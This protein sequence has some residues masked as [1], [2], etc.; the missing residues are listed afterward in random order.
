MTKIRSIPVGS[1]AY[2]PENC[3]TNEDLAKTV[4]TSDEWIRSRTGIKRRH[5]A[6]EG[7]YT[8]DLAISA[9]NSALKDAGLTGADIDLIVVGTTTPDE[10][11][12]STAVK[13]QAALGMDHGFA[14]DVQAVCSGFVYAMTV[15]DNMIR[16]GDIKR[17]LVIGAETLS[18]ILNWEDRTTCV[19]FGDGAGAVMLEASEEEGTL[20]DRGIIASAM[21]SDGR[22]RDL[23][24]VTG[25]PSSTENVGK[26][27]MEGKEI[28]RHAVNNLAAIANEVLENVGLTSDDID[29]V[30]PHQ[31]NQ[32]ILDSTI[33]KLK[34]PTE[35]VIMTVGEH[36]NTSAAS[37]PLA[38]VHAIQ[39]GKV[40]KGDLL[41]MEAMGG[42][43][44]W[45][46]LL[47]RW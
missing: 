36:A 30:I 12:P 43:L 32:R 3:M 19:L 1:G 21:R 16:G 15:A 38:L 23:L 45:G 24:Y 42:G 33:K 34:I 40:K 29:W 11:F 9:A 31:A 22:F 44:T 25:G 37:I 10:T 8:S 18:R 26:I 13:V 39:C 27:V 5:I 28:F 7:Q 41:L 6:A 46:A 4:D 2:L 20:S 35:K 47:I 14:F 17:A